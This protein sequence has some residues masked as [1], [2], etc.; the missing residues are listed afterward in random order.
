MQ[1]VWLQHRTVKRNWPA[2]ETPAP[3]I[4][5]LKCL[6]DIEKSLKEVKR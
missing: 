1:P 2:V 5:G 6:L 4:R 3:V